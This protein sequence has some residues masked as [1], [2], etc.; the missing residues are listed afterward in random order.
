MYQAQ[1]SSTRTWTHFNRR[2][3]LALGATLEALQWRG[4]VI[5]GLPRRLQSQVERCLR[6]QLNPFF[7]ACQFWNR[8]Q[9]LKTGVYAV[10]E[11]RGPA[12]VL[13]HTVSSVLSCY[14][15]KPMIWWPQEQRF[16]HWGLCKI[17]FFLLQI[18]CRRSVYLFTMEKSDYFW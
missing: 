3:G 2:T 15:N 6:Q 5:P 8:Q 11:D 18:Q 14:R 9:P 1:M 17:G 16:N 12:I 7:H 4:S 10:Y 13:C